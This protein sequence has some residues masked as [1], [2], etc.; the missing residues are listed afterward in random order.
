MNTALRNFQNNMY[1]L[2]NS[3]PLPTEAKRLVVCDILYKLEAQADID[4]ALEAQ[5]KLEAQQ[6]KEKELEAQQAKEKESEEE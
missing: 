1:N 6:A 2:I 4:I 5:Q 3:A